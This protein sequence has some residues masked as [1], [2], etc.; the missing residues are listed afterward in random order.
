[1]STVTVTFSSSVSRDE[2]DR[3]DRIVCVDGSQMFKTGRYEATVTYPGRRQN[4]TAQEVAT[5]VRNFL[6]EGFDERIQIW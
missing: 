6:E 2:I 3:I 4:L 1:M 5:F